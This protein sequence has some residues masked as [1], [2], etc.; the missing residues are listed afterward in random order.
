MYLLDVSVLIA[1]AD[2]QHP[3]HIKVYEWMRD[4]ASGWA[5]CPITEN[6]MLRI[7]GHVNYPGGGA[8]SPKDAAVILDGMISAI[9]GHR[10]ISDD[11][12]IREILGENTNVP[13]S[14]LTDMYLLALAVRHGLGF[15]TLDE[16]INPA[17]VHG[18]IDSFELLK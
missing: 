18:G 8:H 2:S 11:Y 14:S 16:R 12:S 1:R 9:P 13:S 3:F 5:T 7:L 17:L 4:H 6:G 15:L 10:F